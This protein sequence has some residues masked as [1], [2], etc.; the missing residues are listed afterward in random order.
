M[1]INKKGSAEMKKIISVIITVVMLMSCLTFTPASAA[2]VNL[3]MESVESVFEFIDDSLSDSAIERI[4]AYN[5]FA[6]YLKTNM[7][8]DT[9]I[10]VLDET[11]VSVP[12]DLAQA[13]GS[14]NLVSKKEELKFVLNLIK[15]LP[16]ERREDGIEEFQAIRQRTEDNGGVEEH[17]ITS[18][19][20]LNEF[21]ELLVSQNGRDKLAVHNVGPNAIVSLLE[22]FRQH[23]MLTDDEVGGN[24]F[25][26]K[27]IY[28]EYDSS[29]F[30]Y[31]DTFNG[32][33]VDGAEEIF[34]AVIETANSYYSAEQKE[35][36]KA[37]FGEIGIYT[38]LT[39]DVPTA[40]PK[41]DEDDKKPSGN[42]VPGII[43]TPTESQSPEDDEELVEVGEA[44]KIAPPEG[45]DTTF[46]DVTNHWAKDYI[47]YLEKEGIIKG[48][49]TGKFEPDWGITREELAVVMIRALKLE[50]KLGTVALSNYLDVAEIS[51]WAR[52]SVA[53]TTKLGIYEGYDD[54]YYRPKRIISR[55][56]LCAILI[57]SMEMS[58]NKVVLNYNDRTQFPD[59]STP[60]IGKATYHGIVSGYPDGEFKPAQNV[61]RAEA[62][63]M[64]YNY[65]QCIY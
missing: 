55:E 48:Y 37:V 38:P 19:D 10:G 52:E 65:M 62:C 11:I 12:G 45:A 46:E 41:P 33:S 31:I 63:K 32:E 50:S 18:Q 47:V 21:Y 2:E 25:A 3:D 28:E 36:I 14:A 27:A 39:E 8:I 56:E 40:T 54:G 57:R 4:D 64:I 29:V 13:L 43:I 59:W 24:N 17:F 7:G 16:E 23:V 42:I 49:D 22:K 1:K 30:E 20:A 61:T 35:S 53:L 51:E 58:G 26:L 34:E 15:A 9:L 44:L 5:I 60:Y 6:T